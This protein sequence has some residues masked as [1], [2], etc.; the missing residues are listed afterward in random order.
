M[1]QSVSDFVSGFDGVGPASPYGHTDRPDALLLGAV[2]QV[3]CVGPGPARGG[4]PLWRLNRVT[5][6]IEA[7]ISGRLSLRELAEV[8]QMSTSHFSRTFH[9]T[10]GMSPHGYV[11]RRRV[12][13]A[14]ALIARTGCAL[15]EVAVMCGTA[16]Q[17]H[18]NRLFARHC[19]IT[20]GAWRR[21]MQWQKAQGAIVHGAAS[22]QTTASHW[23]RRSAGDLL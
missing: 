23:L 18:L 13:A 4:L 12:A 2:Q 3:M 6:H 7:N 20:P 5:R 8:A 19:G 15:A 14:Q 16:D 11:T 17:A 22:Q 10:V 1:A 9:A 21:N